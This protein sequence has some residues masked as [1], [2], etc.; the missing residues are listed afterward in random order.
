[1]GRPWETGGGFFGAARSVDNLSRY[2]DSKTRSLS[3]SIVTLSSK[4]QVVIPKEIR[5]SAGLKPGTSFEV[6]ADENRIEFIPLRPIQDMEGIFP[7]IDTQISRD[8]DRI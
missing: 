4:Y 2:T 8:E 6:M 5:L 3:M 1:M 7:G